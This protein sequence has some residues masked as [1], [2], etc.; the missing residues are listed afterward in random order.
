MSKHIRFAVF[1]H[2]NAR[3]ESAPFERCLE[4]LAR[5]RGVRNIHVGHL[6]PDMI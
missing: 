3:D 5:Q 1:G 4:R 2:E 6:V